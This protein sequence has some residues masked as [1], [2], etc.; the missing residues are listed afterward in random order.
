MHTFAISSVF[1]LEIVVVVVVLLVVVCGGGGGDG[2]GDSIS[3]LEILDVKA[4]SRISLNFLIANSKMPLSEG[5]SLL[6]I[7]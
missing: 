3:D 1:E 6:T 5:A 4:R 7:S 2:L